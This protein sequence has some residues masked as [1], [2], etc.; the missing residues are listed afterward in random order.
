M[1]GS[2]L[3]RS[4]AIGMLAGEAGANSLPFRSEFGFPIPTVV[5]IPRRVMVPETRGSQ[6][7]HCL[8]AG[9]PSV[10]QGCW[11]IT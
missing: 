2:G 1:T 7:L 4:P 9:W 10:Y 8:R 11:K 6:P 3:G 5:L